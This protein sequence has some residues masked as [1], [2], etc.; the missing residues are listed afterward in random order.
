M[1]INKENLSDIRE[2]YEKAHRLINEE[3]KHDPPTEPFRSHYLAR[4]VLNAAL[5]KVK[6][7]AEALDPASEAATTV[8][9]IHANIL[10]D[11]AKITTFVEEP[12]GEVLLKEALELIEAD[13]GKDPALNVH[14][15]ILNQLG[16]MHCNNSNFAESKVF[17]DQAKDIYA[18]AKERELEPLT[19]A[20]LFGTK[21]E[22]EKGKGLKLLESNHTLTLYYLAQV[23]G[24]LDNLSDSARYCRITLKRQLEYNEYEHVDWALNAATLSQYYF[25]RNHLAQARHL[26]AASTYMLHRYEA[27][28]VEKVTNPEERAE[29]EETLRYRMADIA[30]CWAK[31]GL[32]IL[33][34]SKERLSKDDDSDEE[35]PKEAPLTPVRKM[36]RF[37]GLEL[38]PYEDQVTDEF[39]LTFDDAK[40]VMLNS[41]SWLNK[42]KEYYTKETE[43][44]QYS[45]IVQ[46]IASLYKH[47]SFF[48]EDEGNQCKLLKRS[49]DQLE[50]IIETLNPTYYQSICREV[51]YELGLT[52]SNM[53]NIKLGQLDDLQA[54][55]RPTPHALNK[56]NHLCD[57]SIQNFKKFLTSYKVPLDTLQLPASVEEGEM[58]P[59][60]YALFHIGR[61]Y[62]RI[63]T[64][65]KRLKLKNTENSL[66]YYGQFVECCKDE[67]T[68]SMFVQEIGVCK[69][70]TSLLP[71]KIEKLKAE[72]AQ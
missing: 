1:K 50:E 72:I 57:K 52:Y 46:D 13:R 23:F 38:A 24:F 49:V 63:I 29:K 19:M 2:E 40:L 53:L 68:K 45:K 54:T 59:L 28:I 14:I 15:E 65:D 27:E 22:V 51:W 55:E 36:E 48:E 41:L 71:L 32:H 8:R 5:R 6:T 34:A 12:N 35:G 66:L 33:C 67:R 60:L 18:D 3:S 31:Y 58:Q 42:A 26:L 16:I 70:M 44:T 56:I 39:C 64:P 4:D 20:D 43:A 11:I 69:E 47:L 62:Y 61:L 17:L 21:E 10:K 9:C 30:R 25:P 7:L 37:V